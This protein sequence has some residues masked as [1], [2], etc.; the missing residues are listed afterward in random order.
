MSAAED[1]AP[2]A[3]GESP[4]PHAL[5]FYCPYCGEQDIRPGPERATYHCRTCDRL[6][7]LE[8]KRLGVPEQSD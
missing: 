8:Y 3:P 7:R 2:R 4:T 6:W 5:P 1:R